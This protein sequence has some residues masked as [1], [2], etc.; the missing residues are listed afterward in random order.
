MRQVPDEWYNDDL[1]ARTVE[2]RVAWVT[3]RAGEDAKNLTLD[4][5]RVRILED[6]NGDGR[7][8]T[9]G[10]FSDGYHAV[11]DGIAAGILARKGEVYLANIPSLYL[12]KDTKGDG[13]ADQ[14]KVLATGFGVH[15]QLIGHD[16]HGLRMGPDGRLYF[17]LGDRG[18]NVTTKAGK[19]LEYPNTGAVLR[20]DPAGS[21]LEA[22]HAGLRNLQEIAFDE[23]GNLFTFHNTS[24]RGD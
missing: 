16:L 12:L 13:H 10:L 6:V 7:A 20:C 18:F 24:D 9:A 17:S 3:K 8:D 23:Y 4:S 22:V 11:A 1:A 21:N 2:D 5:D 14:K 15:Y 19:K